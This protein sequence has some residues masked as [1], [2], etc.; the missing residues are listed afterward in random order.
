MTEEKINQGIFRGTRVKSTVTGFSA[1]FW[2]KA[3]N[4]PALKWA[5]SLNAR[6]ISILRK[7]IAQIC[8][9]TTM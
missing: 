6:K 5:G 4:T 3:A 2:P 8:D 7:I 9:V 1:T